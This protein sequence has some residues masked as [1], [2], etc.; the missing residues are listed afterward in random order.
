MPRRRRQPKKSSS[1]GEWIRTALFSFVAFLGGVGV[2][3]LVEF[4]NFIRSLEQDKYALTAAQRELVFKTIE[5]H[6]E[7]QKKEGRPANAPLHGI[8]YMMALEEG[9]VLQPWTTAIMC[10]LF[11]IDTLGTA[12]QAK[13]ALYVTDALIT[14]AGSSAVQDEEVSLDVLLKSWDTSWPIEQYVIPWN[15]AQATV[16]VIGKPPALAAN[17]CERALNDV[18][19]QEASQTVSIQVNF[20]CEAQESKWEK[21]QSEIS[22]DLSD[23]GIYAEWKSPRTDK[24]FAR[25]RPTFRSYLAEDQLTPRRVVAVLRRKLANVEQMPRGLDADASKRVPRY[26]ELWL[27]TTKVCEKAK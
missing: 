9:E 17:G 22:D 2:P 19:E 24:N 11:A 25:S 7:Q 18:I 5:I 16:S 6:R 10:R 15:D 23:I 21:T 8:G 20:A 12:Q 27:E 3:A 4:G 1:T 26:F 14:Q 13:N